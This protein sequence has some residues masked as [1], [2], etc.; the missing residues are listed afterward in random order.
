MATCRLCRS[1]H[2]RGIPIRGHDQGS[3]TD[4]KPLTKRQ[5]E[6]L[7]AV[8]QSRQ[9]QHEKAPPDVLHDCGPL[10]PALCHEVIWVA[11]IHRE[12]RC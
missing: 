7:V 11:C 4:G 12:R 9:R 3:S 1:P 8:S 5:A 10:Q 6:L 2:Q